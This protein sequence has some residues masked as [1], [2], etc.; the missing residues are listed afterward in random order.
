VNNVG[1]NNNDPLGAIFEFLVIRQWQYLAGISTCGIV[2]EGVDLWGDF[3]VSNGQATHNVFLLTA[4]SDV[5]L[6]AP[7]P[8]PCLP[9]CNHVSS[10][11]VN[12][13]KL[14]NC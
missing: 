4:E 2:G 3:G 14:S 8:G 7:S 11:M 6:S 13:L 1:L 5:K 10:H 9:A 12:E